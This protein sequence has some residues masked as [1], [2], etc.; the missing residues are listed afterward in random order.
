MLVSHDRYFLDRMTT[1]TADLIR[2][3]IDSYP[4][5]YEHYL[6]ARQERRIH[7]QARHRAAGFGQL[8]FPV[9]GTELIKQF[10]TIVDGTTIGRLNKR[11][12]T[13]IAQLQQQHL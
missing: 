10:E 2:G 6:E 4:G 8:A 7:W 13:D 9:D 5:N 1:S 3:Q 12:L 11:K